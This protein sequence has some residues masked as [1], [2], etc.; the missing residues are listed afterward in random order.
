MRRGMKSVLAA[1][2][3]ASLFFGSAS[4]FAVTA[5]AGQQTAG[6]AYVEPEY[7][8]ADAFDADTAE[9]ENNDG[10]DTYISNNGTVFQIPRAS[11]ADERL[12]DY[13]GIFTEEQQNL[14]KEKISKLEK[15]K[16]CT[17]II[18]TSNDVPYDVN[19]G[20]ETTS[21]YIRQFY[22]DNG[23]E[24]NGAGFII[25]L[26]NHVLWSIGSGKF[27]TDDFVDFSETV[28]NDCLSAAR[29]GDY[30]AAAETFCSD[31]EK[32]KNVLYAAK[33]TVL[34]VIISAVAALI[35]M[36]LL[37]LLHGG[38][39]P[40]KANTPKVEVKAFKEKVHDEK[41]LGTTVTRRHIPKHDDSDSG[42]GGGFSGGHSSGGFSSGGGSFSGG[43]GK[44]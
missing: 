26:N 10:D 27:N 41:Y 22:I 24:T 44:F 15:S 12:F 43:G 6:E 37:L 18:L 34:S 14:L 38:T 16:K 2:T 32:Y 5:A 35:A 17:V 19:D 21:K 28:Y 31:F 30:Y 29:K 36:L 23:Y 42:G 1:I 7:S 39:K 13:A 3:A 4:A 8:E 11:D 9:A 40:S 20:S 25:D 33:P